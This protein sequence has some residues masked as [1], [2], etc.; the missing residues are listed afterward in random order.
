MDGQ[1]CYGFF[2][3]GRKRDDGFMIPRRRNEHDSAS[4]AYW[5]TGR[6]RVIPN[7]LEHEFSVCLCEQFELY[8]EQ[9]YMVLHLQQYPLA[10]IF[11]FQ[12]LLCRLRNALHSVLTG[13]CLMRVQIGGMHSVFMELG[14]ASTCRR[15]CR[16]E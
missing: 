7:S 8:K 12:S 4:T 10:L 1:S 2:G 6:K 5:S 16:A 13:G 14:K 9:G 3:L 15:R 11:P